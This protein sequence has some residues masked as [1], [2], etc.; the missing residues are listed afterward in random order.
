MPLPGTLVSAVISQKCT[1]KASFVRYSGKEF[2][3][4]KY[5]KFGFWFIMFVKLATVANMNSEPWGD[6][7]ARLGDRW[8]SYSTFWQ[9]YRTDLLRKSN[10]FQTN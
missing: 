6:T 9:C 7:P 5:S 2:T 10:Y 3:A 8:C 4:L 1:L